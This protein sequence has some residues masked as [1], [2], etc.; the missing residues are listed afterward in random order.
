MK[1]AI[2][3]DVEDWYQTNGL[4]LPISTWS[5]Y[6]DRLVIHTQIILRLLA[7]YNVKGTFFILGCVAQKHPDLVKEINDGG[8]E[9][10][11]HGGW[12]QMLH[13]M[14]LAEFRTD[15]VFSKQI[16]EQISGQK[17]VLYRA[18]SWSISSDNYEV[19]QI[20]K[21]EG[22]TCDSSLQPFRTPLS[23]INNAP[24]KPFYPIIKGQKIGILEFPQTVLRLG[25]F[26]FPFSGGFYMRL[27]PS[28]II[29]WALK[30]IN[31]E[32]PGMI[33]FH[34]WEFDLLQPRVKTTPLIRLAQY[35]NLKSTEKK[36]EKLLQQ[37]EFVP[38]GQI[39]QEGQF[40]DKALG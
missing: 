2:T 9:I 12:H 16:L 6:V 1:N 30:I 39:I 40:P 5:Q 27:M 22:F 14:T 32:G 33:Y 28:F 19:L 26:T 7:K 29:S 13:K 10:A 34:P 15:V 20:L 35:Y 25:K 21:E 4:D 11:S 36:L 38:L 8:H 23:G 17:V 37:F 18:P 31:R 24:S 3:I